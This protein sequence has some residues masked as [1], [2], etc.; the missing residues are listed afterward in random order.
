MC[1]NIIS[2][3]EVLS[4]VDNEMKKKYIEESKEMVERLLKE[5]RDEVC[6]NKRYCRGNSLKRWGYN[7]WKGIDTE[8]G[9]I[10]GIKVPRI[11]DITRNKEIEI[12][13]RTSRTSMRLQDLITGSV[14]NGQ[15]LRSSSAWLF[16]SFGYEISAR[17]ISNILNKVESVIHRRRNSPINWR[18]YVGIV[19]DG[20]WFTQRRKRGSKN[21]AK[22]KRVILAAVGVN[23]YGKYKVLDWECRASEDLEGYKL[24]LERL[25]SRGLEYIQIA[26]GDE[27]PSI[28]SAVD[29][30]YPFALKQSCLYHF[31]ETLKRKLTSA[32]GS[33]R[34]FKRDFW[35]I[36]NCDTEK[37]AFD[38][39]ESFKNKWYE[40][41]PDAVAKLIKDFEKTI[42]YLKIPYWW[43]Y[44]LRTT[45][46]AEGF[47]RNLRRY[48]GRFPGFNSLK[49]MLRAFAVYLKGAESCSWRYSY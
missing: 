30:V 27:E 23:G 36:Y 29:L 1:R 44:R 25:Y 40:K 38:N 18:D 4:Q 47:F 34:R 20:V 22:Q 19:L 7:T 37:E 28:W 43:N 9:Y 35:N 3:C 12:I 15:S 24:L 32:P 2:L 42:N 5:I 13:S 26:V 10:K 6:G 14:L 48:L 46:L 45:N 49:H 17:S 21:S 41:E 33:R 11:R 39:L 31:Q 8:L 16:N